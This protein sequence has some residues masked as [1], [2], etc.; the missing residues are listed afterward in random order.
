ML[1][2]VVVRSDLLLMVQIN[3][4]DRQWERNGRNSVMNRLQFSADG[5]ESAQ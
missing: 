4:T 5:A 3:R 1:Y 2:A